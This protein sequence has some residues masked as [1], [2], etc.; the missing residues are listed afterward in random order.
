MFKK[1]IDGSLYIPTRAE[2]VGNTKIAIVN[3]INSGSD[4]DKYA[5][6]G[7]LYDGL[8]KQDDPFN[9][10][11]GQWMDNM[12][13]FKKTGRYATIPIALNLYDNV[14]QSIPV[15]VNK[16]TYAS[17]WTNND[18]KV[19]EFNSQYPEISKGDL[20]VSRY[21][22]QLVTYTPSTYL[23]SKTSASARIPLKYN[24][25]ESL[26]LNWA[27]LSS[28]LIKEYSDHIDFYLNNFRTDTTTATSDIIKVTGATTQPTYTLTK[29]SEATAVATPTWNATEGTYTL[30]ISH[31]G[32][33][34]VSI[35]CAGNAT[36]RSTD[37]VNSSA[38]S[39]DLPK[40]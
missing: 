2:V 9:K 21:K 1:V 11:T 15:K 17:R 12:C 18:A 10:G 14:A 35:K 19:A 33:V 22:N 32:P 5:A 39:A 27:K 28:G 24:T 7:D 26:N 31:Q 37:M 38:L 23:N 30:E 16:S 20:Y 4:E 34:D 3:D 40:H 13:Y 36:G 6:W 8:Y 29:R 25:C